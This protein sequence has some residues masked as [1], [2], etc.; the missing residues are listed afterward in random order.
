MPVKLKNPFLILTKKERPIHLAFWILGLILINVPDWHVNL[1]VFHSDDFSLIIPSIYGTFL[2]AYLFYECS[3][4]IIDS[5][6]TKITDAVIGTLLTLLAV[7]LIEAFLD[8]GFYAIYFQTINQDTF[9][10]IVLNE[11]LSDF[12]FV[13]LPAMMYSFIKVWHPK[14]E[15]ME[16]EPTIQIEDG[17][18][19]VEM[20]PKKLTH[21]ENEGNFCLYHGTSK[22]L[23]QQTIE[24]AQKVLPA[25]F[26]RCHESFLVNTQRVR[27]LASD[28]LVVGGFIVPVSKAYEE[29]IDNALSPNIPRKR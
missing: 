15:K 19:V 26:V 2:N 5:D 21:I 27:T 1:G 8:A 6:F 22:K 3:R 14:E 24:E 12:I 23:I 10:E 17:D 9:T 18:A 11:V 7:T 4:R 28:E 20:N 29:K 25:Y 13:Y 16:E